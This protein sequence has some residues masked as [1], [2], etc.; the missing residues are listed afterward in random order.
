MSNK[1]TIAKITKQYLKKQTKEFDIG[2]IFTLSLSSLGIFDL[3][4]LNE[5]TGL[6]ILDLSNNNISSMSLLAPLKQL[7][8][9]NLSRNR[10]SSIGGIDELSSLSWLDLSSNFINSIDMLRPLRRLEK[11][12]HLRLNDFTEG[13]SNP[14]C[15][16]NVK[17]KTDAKQLLPGLQTLDGQIL[18]G[19]GREFSDLCEELDVK[20]EEIQGET[21]HRRKVAVAKEEYPKITVDDFSRDLNLEGHFMHQERRIKELLERCEIANSEAEKTVVAAENSLELTTGRDT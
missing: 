7:Q 9:L 2:C 1:E 4:C 8:I 6:V 16:C 3:G 11:F 13:L 14:V 21:I 20:L 19:I 12:A 17:Y 15:Q 18:S 10:L 5:C